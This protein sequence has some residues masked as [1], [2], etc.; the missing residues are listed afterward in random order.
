[1]KR[2]QIMAYNPWKTDVQDTTWGIGYD[3]E[4]KLYEIIQKAREEYAEQCI[5]LYYEDGQVVT[6]QPLHREQQY[7]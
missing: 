6:Y 1:M 3:S 4:S 2:L 5:T 7:I